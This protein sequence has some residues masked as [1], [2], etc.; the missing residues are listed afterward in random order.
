MDP[1]PGTCR[2]REVC[3]KFQ[4]RRDEGKKDGT[5]NEERPQQR[6]KENANSTGWFQDQ[7]PV[8]PSMNG[9]EKITV[10]L[11]RDRAEIRGPNRKKR[12][13]GHFQ[14]ANR[15]GNTRWEVGSPAQGSIVKERKAGKPR[16]GKRPIISSG[17]AGRQGREGFRRCV[18]EKALKRGR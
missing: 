5:F 2:G 6:E 10:L 11:G 12:E 15:D 9:G 4:K 14:T 1:R 16:E 13:K 7:E 3:A 18:S 8:C 17:W